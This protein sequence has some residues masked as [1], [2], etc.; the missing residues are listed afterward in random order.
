MAYNPLAFGQML[1]AMGSLVFAAYLY[2]QYKN[3]KDHKLESGFGGIFVLLGLVASIFGFGLFVS[4]PIP[5]HYIEVYGVGYMVYTMLML[6]LGATL[7]FKWDLRPASYLGVVGGI[8]LLNS[9]YTIWINQMS[10]HPLATTI[11]FLLAG[12]GALGS[13]LMAHGD[14]D[15]KRKL[16][17]LGMLLFILFGLLTL[18]SGMQSQMGHVMSALAE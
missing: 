14:I 18:Y 16:F 5:G 12:L 6:I 10:K 8:A 15:K 2:Y 3:S 4:Q 17:L 13:P 11:V 7:I 9:A 1:V